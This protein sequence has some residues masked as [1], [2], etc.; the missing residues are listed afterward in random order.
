MATQWLGTSETLRKEEMSCGF[1]RDIADDLC[2]PIDSELDLNI[3]IDLYE[4]KLIYLRNLYAQAFRDLNG[5]NCVGASQEGF[6]SQDLVRIRQLLTVTED[7][8]KKDCVDLVKHGLE[9][10]NARALRCAA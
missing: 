1:Y 9:N 5:N 10:A 2:A 6:T 8:L 4:S 3:R 7:F